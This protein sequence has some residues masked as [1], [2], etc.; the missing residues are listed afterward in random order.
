VANVG[1]VLPLWAGV[2]GTEIRARRRGSE[3]TA[4]RAEARVAMV[5]T[6][7]LLGIAAFVS[8]VWPFLRGPVDGRVLLGG[9]V[10]IVVG[11]V[12]L[13]ALRIRG[14]LRRRRARDA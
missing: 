11:G 1:V 4:P 14:A 7:V 2:I 3:R 9:A 5:L 12:L 6:P 13:L 8:Q 10:V